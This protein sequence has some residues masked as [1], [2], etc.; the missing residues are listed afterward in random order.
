M[1][2]IFILLAIVLIAGC[3]KNIREASSNVNAAA[4]A[5]R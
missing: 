3:D 4:V 1:K 2:S 5:S